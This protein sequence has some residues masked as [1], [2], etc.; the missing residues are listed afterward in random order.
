MKTKII[1]L[2][3]VLTLVINCDKSEMV[4]IFDLEGN[5]ISELEFKLR[6]ETGTLVL[7]YQNGNKK[8]LTTLID[9]DPIKEIEWYENGTKKRERV[10]KGNFS[11]CKEITWYENGKKEREK[12]IKNGTDHGKEISWYEN[13]KKRSEREYFEGEPHGRWSFWDENGQ[14]RLIWEYKNGKPHGKSIDW[15][16]D[17]NIT[18]EAIFKDG[19]MISDKY[20][21]KNKKNAKK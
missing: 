3:F 6:R 13:G 5:K 11:D 18:R 1:V 21:Q 8:A 14:L 16:K 20:P 4:D 17:G 10:Y 7:Y 12:E 9:G 15:D 2:I 19:K